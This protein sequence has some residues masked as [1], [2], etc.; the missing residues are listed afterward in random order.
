MIGNLFVSPP[1]QQLRLIEAKLNQYRPE[2]RVL[3]VSQ[4]LGTVAS[5]AALE[6]SWSTGRVTRLLTISPPLPSPHKTMQNPRSKSKRADGVMKTW[7]LPKDGSLSIDEDIMT[8]RLATVPKEY[9]LEHSAV[10]DTFHD[11]LR[12]A[13]ESGEAMAV[14]TEA[15]WN[16]YA[17][18][19][20]AEWEDMF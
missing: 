17:K 13:V 14:A 16:V 2:D 12:Y 19:V 20:M 10:S 6:N 8:L 9:E 5:L 4:C 18:N 7:D 15:D 11:R 1:S 3:I